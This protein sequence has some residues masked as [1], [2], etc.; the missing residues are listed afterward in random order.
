MDCLWHFRRRGINLIPL[1]AKFL[2]DRG[3]V[4]RGTGKG[5]PFLKSTA[6]GTVG[7]RSLLVQLG[8]FRESKK[9]LKGG[10]NGC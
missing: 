7:K 6:E 10:E 8:A 5:D 3:A 2:Q 9:C 1:R 4:I